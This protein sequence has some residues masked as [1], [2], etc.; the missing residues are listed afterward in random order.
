MG[1][2]GGS[3]GGG[4]TRRAATGEKPLRTPRLRDVI[5][6][7]QTLANEYGAS[8]DRT[9]ISS[10]GITRNLREDEKRFQKQADGNY[11]TKPYQDTRT[12]A[13]KDR[14]DRADA[15][16][17]KEREKAASAVETVE[18]EEEEEETTTP[19]TAVDTAQQNVTQLANTTVSAEASNRPRSQAETEAAADQTAGY[20]SGTI[21]TSP[22][23]VSNEDTSG[24]RPKKSAM[25]R[26]GL[27]ANDDDPKKK[28]TLIA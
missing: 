4:E 6:N 25:A 13:Q 27:L 2:S 20:K 10:G 8:E 11:I 24:L 7:P 12:D 18:D 14:D 22:S 3:S 28:K 16:A 9:I 5:T 23:G 26:T 19:A 17:A 21:A 1:D 15:R